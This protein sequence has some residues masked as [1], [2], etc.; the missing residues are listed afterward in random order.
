M[1]HQG[2]NDVLCSAPGNTVLARVALP[3]FVQEQL[4]ALRVDAGAGSASPVP[5]PGHPRLHRRTQQHQRL[6]DRL[7]TGSYREPATLQG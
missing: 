3:D 2:L 7:Q 4:H 5:K 1:E 6:L